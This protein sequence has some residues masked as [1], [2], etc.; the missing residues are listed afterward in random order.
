MCIVVDRFQFVEAIDPMPKTIHK[1]SIGIL[2]F[3]QWFFILLFVL[4]TK[5]LNE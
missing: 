1:L 4:P 5:D 3:I 2:M